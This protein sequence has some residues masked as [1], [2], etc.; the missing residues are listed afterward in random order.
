VLA[1]KVA[2]TD[3]REVAATQA[4]YRH[5]SRPDIRL[6]AVASGLRRTV[7]CAFG[8]KRQKANSAVLALLYVPSAG[9]V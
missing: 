6:V 8:K 1:A 4:R 7:P 5:K 9:S 2:A 3:G